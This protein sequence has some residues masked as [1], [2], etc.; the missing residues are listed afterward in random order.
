M[1][2]IK[3]L[4]GQRFNHLVVIERDFN[5]PYKGTY[6]K[7]LCDCGNIT[8]VKSTNL[9]NDLVKSCGCLVH[10]KHNTHHLSQEP[11]YRLWNSIKRR[12]YDEKHKA[13]KYYGRRGI[14]MCPE[15][16]D[17]ETFYK[18]AN[19]NG[20]KRGL[21]IDRRDN[22][23]GYNPDN[24]KWVSAKVQ[25]NNRRSCRMYSY[26]GKTQNL[27]QWCEEL[28]LNYKRVYS[29]LNKYHWD[30]KKAITEPLDPRVGKVK[31][32]GIYK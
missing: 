25:A 9:R 3:D 21:S 30:F 22:Q 31:N 27:T 15:W 14:T 23:K 11:L 13:Y 28:N 12:C 29:R 1:S 20:Y 17:F 19:E 16:L 18:W 2:T 24:C 5:S 8:S 4:I 6:W 26:N 32:D 10:E 7:C